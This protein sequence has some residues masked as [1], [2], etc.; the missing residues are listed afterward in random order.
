LFQGRC[1]EGDDGLLKA[2]VIIWLKE[3]F[4]SGAFKPLE[5]RYVDVASWLCDNGFAFR[6]QEFK[7]LATRIQP[8]KSEVGDVD[9]AVK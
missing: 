5:I 7:D 9:D 3:T 8:F 6:P 1:E 2:P 4:V